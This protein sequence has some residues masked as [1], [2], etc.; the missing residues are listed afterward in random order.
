MKRTNLALL[1]V[2]VPVLVIA[3]AL[4]PS[5]A[6]GQEPLSGFPEGETKPFHLELGAAWASFD[7][8]AG[9]YLQNAQGI[10]GMLDFE[11][12]FG[13]PANSVTFS[14][15]GWWRWGKRS[16]IEIGWISFD[17]SG[18]KT[19][20]EDITWGEYTIKAQGSVDA[21]FKSREAYVGYRYDFWQDERVRVSG[22]IGF[23]L[24]KI[25][26][27]LSA[28]G[29]VVKPDGTEISGISNRE[30]SLSGPIPL[31]GFDVDAAISKKV[32]CTFTFRGIGINLDEISGNV[33]SSY[34]GVKW[35][36]HPNLGVSGGFSVDKQTLRHYN[37]G[38]YDARANF[39]QSGMKLYLIGSF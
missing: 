10:G 34:L 25:S 20:T 7:T 21:A 17:R 39:M 36:F 8:Q 35:Y 33:I 24:T 27:S 3:A 19:L 12:L 22:T 2:L 6:L 38:D 37:T 9:L 32:T 23:G 29:K 16:S 13:L 28:S 18:T 5:T 14:G 4:A 1:P 31:I 15:T 30:F 11:Q 26:G